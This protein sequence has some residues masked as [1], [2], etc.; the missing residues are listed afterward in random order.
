MFPEITAKQ[1]RQAHGLRL[2]GAK[3]EALEIQSTDTK[4]V[5]GASGDKYRFFFLLF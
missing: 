1:R 4:Y 5:C 2:H 3:C